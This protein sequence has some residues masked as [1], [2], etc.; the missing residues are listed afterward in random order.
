MKTPPILFVDD[1]PEICELAMI[2]IQRMDLQ[3]RTADTLAAAKAALLEDNFSLC[4]TDMRLPDG[5]GIDLVR[6]IQQRYPHLPVAVITAHGN[7]QTAVAAL[8]AGAF[9]FVAKPLHLDRLRKLVRS[10]LSLPKFQEPSEETPSEDT[11]GILGNSAAMRR[12]RDLIGRLARSQASIYIS[13]AS[14]TGKELA[15]RLIHAQSARHDSPFI[16]VNCG[17]IP[18]ELMESEFFGHKR[19]S[20]TGATQDKQGLIKAADG[21]TLFLDEVADLPLSM[22]VKLLRTLQ[23]NTIRPVGSASEQSTD[24]RFLCAT[25]AN[26]VD[27]VQNNLFREDLFYRLNVIELHMPS[28]CEHTED[29]PALTAHLLQKITAKQGIPVPKIT[30]GA[31]SALQQYTFP[32]NVRELENIIERTLTLYEGNEITAGD[33][34][35]Q[36]VSSTQ[37]TGYVPG[38]G[39]LEAYLQSIERNAFEDALHMT[40]GNK[41]EA[42][43]LLGMSFRAFR[44]KLEKL[45]E[46]VSQDPPAY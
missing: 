5:N 19:G 46:S 39:T 27:R 45:Q 40:A 1:E 34:K 3:C 26:L 25:H 28:L 31:F 37:Q 18:L 23:E 11:M 12:I 7:V 6:E 4:L 42:A 2:S 8:K 24:V 29:I 14:G 35:F 41:T 38:S 16:P 13:G 30:P 33:L 20:F 21:G 36:T 15:A 44:Y 17:A 10:A 32:G 22:Q 9:D 43:A